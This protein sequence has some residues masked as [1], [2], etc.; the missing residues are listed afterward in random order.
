[1]AGRKQEPLSCPP[2]VL[3]AIP[4]YPDDLTREER[5]AVD[6]HASE[7]LDC[8]RELEARLA[9]P[10]QEAQWPTPDPERTLTR[11]LARIEIGEAETLSEWARAPRRERA[12]RWLRES[13]VRV[14]GFARP[15]PVSRGLS[16]VASF[17]AAVAAAALFFGAGPDG[18]EP[19]PA[20]HP[21][22]VHHEAP[23]LDV[24]FRSDLSVAELAG[25]IEGIHGEIVAGPSPRGRYRIQLPSGTSAESA[26]QALS[27]TGV[28]VY[29]E[30]SLE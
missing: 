10:G 9:D 7:C 8:R 29:A 12:V 27:D 30:P 25:A 23:R 4:W 26:A 21:A 14:P 13:E 17:G 24:V 5:E 1:M 16:A 22:A 11:V 20:P 19:A 2:E 15:V 6:S 18:S 3:A 28:A